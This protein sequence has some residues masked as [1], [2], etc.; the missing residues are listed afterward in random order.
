MNQ[1]KLR[2]SISA[3]EDRALSNATAVTIFL[4]I[5]SNYYLLK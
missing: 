3:L 1:K 4:E 2:A 5:I